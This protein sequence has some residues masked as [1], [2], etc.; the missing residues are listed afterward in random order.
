MYGISD[1]KVKFVKIYILQP[2]IL[3]YIDIQIDPAFF[4]INN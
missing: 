1:N 3:C 4:N 2:I